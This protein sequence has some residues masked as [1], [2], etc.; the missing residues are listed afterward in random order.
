VREAFKRHGLVYG[1][2][3]LRGKDG[4]PVYLDRSSA[5][6]EVEPLFAQGL[7]AILDHPALEHELKNLERRPGAGGKDR[8]NRPIGRGMLLGKTWVKQNVPN[9]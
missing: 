7:I 6:L 4:E 2:V 8:V 1:D 9:V 5:Y 3:T